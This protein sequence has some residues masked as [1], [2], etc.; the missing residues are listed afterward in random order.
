MSQQRAV[1]ESASN[2][3]TS[4]L[5][6]TCSQLRD[7]WFHRRSNALFCTRVRSQRKTFSW[8]IT[9]QAVGGFCGFYD[10]PRRRFNSGRCFQWLGAAS[11]TRNPTANR[12]NDSHDMHRS[13]CCTV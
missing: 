7:N 1:W 4:T 6:S 9:V 5:I 13:R 10:T 12:N 11:G 2:P 8:N 3:I